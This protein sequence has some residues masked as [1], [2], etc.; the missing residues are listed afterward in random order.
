MP[1]LVYRQNGCPGADR[2]RRDLEQQSRALLVGNSVV[3][4]NFSQIG[5]M[6]GSELPTGGAIATAEGGKALAPPIMASVPKG[7]LDAQSHALCH[8]AGGLCR[9]GRRAAPELVGLLDGAE[10]VTASYTLH[11][12]RPR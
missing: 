10:A 1:V 2:H 7:Q 12:D 3:D 9:S 8:G 6:S 5:P 4:A 11:R